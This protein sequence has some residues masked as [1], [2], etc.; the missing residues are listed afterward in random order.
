MCNRILLFLFFFPGLLGG[1]K[2]QKNT[3]IAGQIH[4]ADT[5]K[6][7]KLF[8][9][10]NVINDAAMQK[11]IA[12]SQGNFQY[13]GKLEMPAYFRIDGFMS[14]PELFIE[15]GDSL[16]FDIRG[17]GYDSIKITGIGYEKFDLLKELHYNVFNIVKQRLSGLKVSNGEDYGKFSIFIDSL[18]KSAVNRI[19]LYENKISPG[20]LDVIKAYA[21]CSLEDQ[22][23][24]RLFRLWI[25]KDH[26]EEIS[27]K[28]LAAM[29]DS[30]IGRSI[31]ND[32]DL[33]NE[34]IINTAAT[35]N[36]SSMVSAKY[37][38][39]QLFNKKMDSLVSGHYALIN[40]EYSGR[41]RDKLLYEMFETYLRKRPFDEVMGSLTSF[42][43]TTGASPYRQDLI[44]MREKV[45]QLSPGNIA[46]DF[47]LVDRHGNKVTKRDLGNK[48]VLMDFWFTGCAPCAKLVKT[49]K[50]VEEKFH[51]HPG[52]V[53]VNISIDRNKSTWMESLNEKRYTTGSGI[54]LYTEGKG[55]GHDM[56][57]SYQVK[58][59]PRLVLL[60]KK[61][62]IVMAMPPDPRPNDENVTELIEQ[63]NA[64]LKL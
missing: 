46:P 42:L 31:M 32:I 3:I 55:T 53:F 11:S 52:V 36:I 28:D 20:S 61:G 5:M 44:E 27:G 6:Q 47:E 63:I 8:L 35:G 38:R 30:T 39:M 45:L 19:K 2:G 59:F 26:S 58:G 62:K 24:G 25:S 23:R 64:Q 13:K 9:V 40:K 18:Q 17:K 33:S 1:I 51:E 14:Y 12:V 57:S 60:D 48:V 50:Q 15:P 29:Y 7:L 10:D 41:M 21:V 49:L 22:R 54:C 37:T 34:R 56:I 43:S 4:P 16:Y